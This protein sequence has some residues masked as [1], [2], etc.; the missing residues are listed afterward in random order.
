M[1]RDAQ[2]IDR[3]CDMLAGE[4]GASANTL[5]A[6]RR[7]LEQAS[8]DLDGELA[9]ATGEKLSKLTS[10]WAPL[11]ASTVARKVSVVRGFYGFL[12]DE[13][14]RADSPAHA[15]PRPTIR[16]PLPKILSRD[17]VDR[18]FACLT[19][20]TSKDEPKLADLRL[21][22][23]IELLY[24][25]G[26]RASELCNL[27]RRTFRQDQAY[28]IL[29]GKGGQ[30]RMVPLSDAARR[31]LAR[32]AEHVPEDQPWLFPARKGPMS[33]ISL[34][35]A[36]KKLAAEASIDPA[37][38]SPHVL[39]HAFATHLLEGGADLRAVQSMLGH[40]DIATTE[41]YTHVDSAR[42]VQLVNERHPLKEAL[43]RIDGQDREP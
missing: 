21:S 35:Q 43:A 34:F 32:W 17:E 19:E 1:S 9:D 40:A 36:V 24:G 22:A 12:E 18:L 20:R 42:L 3:Y 7:D 27:P 30:E 14:E 37:R 5:D 26:L 16:R 15:L 13:G 4:Q 25:S 41:I 6:Y 33:R 28:L 8:G 39:R 11:A 31:A 38:V 29:K 2:L 23:M 10:I